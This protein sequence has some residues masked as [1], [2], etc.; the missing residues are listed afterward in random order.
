MPTEKLSTSTTT[1]NSHSPSVKW[2][3]IQ[4]FV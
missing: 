2:Y 3:E 1:E 4:I